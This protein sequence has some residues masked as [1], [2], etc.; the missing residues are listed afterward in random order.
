MLAAN[1]T[2][3]V[4]SKY[5]KH[6]GGLTVCLFFPWLRQS[7][8]LHVS[9]LLST[10]AT[11]RSVL[12][13]RLSNLEYRCRYVPRYGSFLQKIVMRVPCRLV[14]C[15]F[16]GSICFVSF[17]FR[18][19]LLQPTGQVTLSASTATALI[20]ARTLPRTPTLMKIHRRCV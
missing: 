1:V 15:C 20:S 8:S 6:A 4:Y 5:L 9:H 19:V 17:S 16:F 14:Q 3:N 7:Y 12:P 2:T 18:L 13:V 11:C 10:D